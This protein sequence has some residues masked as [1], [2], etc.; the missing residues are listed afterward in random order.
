MTAL[1]LY[2]GLPVVTL[3]GCSY[4]ARFGASI[5]KAAGREEWIT[6]S[7]EEYVGKA[8]ELGGDGAKLRQER[9]MLFEEIV[10]SSL[11]DVQG[12][13][14]MMGEALLKKVMA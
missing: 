11:L 5:L 12:Y 8:L 1:A 6:G 2:F 13:S 7:V 9:E 14:E 4:G 3:R 10:A